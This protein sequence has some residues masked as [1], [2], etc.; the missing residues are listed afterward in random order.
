MRKNA[1]GTTKSISN[2]PRVTDLGIRKIS[3]MNFS[4][5]VTLPKIFVRN[6]LNGQITTLVRLTLLEDGSL[7][8][9][10]V[11]EKDDPAEFVVM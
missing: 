11:H 4:H 8:L 3:R 7:K 1:P 5:I 2:S 6:N 9:T 10:P